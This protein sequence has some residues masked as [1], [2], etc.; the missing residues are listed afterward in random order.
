MAI[1]TKLTAKGVDLHI[2]SMGLDTS[3]ATGK[4]ILNVMGAI[5]EFERAI[6]LE[7]QRLGIAKAKAE[8][9]FKGR[10][11][12]AQRKAKE[13]IRLRSE[14]AKALEIAKE[15]GTSRASVFRVLTKTKVSYF[16]PSPRHSMVAWRV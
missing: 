11:P 16:A 14:G 1:T 2:L 15:L 8:G 6:M 5:A 10:A 4:L 3:T 9:K 12:T 13:V 7:R